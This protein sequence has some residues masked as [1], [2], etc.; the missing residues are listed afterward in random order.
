MYRA[1][2]I[3][4]IH[5]NLQTQEM[6]SI[7]ISSHPSLPPSTSQSKISPNK[8]MPVNLTPK[9]SRWGTPSAHQKALS[10]SQSRKPSLCLSQVV[11]L[12]HTLSRD[13]ITPPILKPCAQQPRPAATRLRA[14]PSSPCWRGNSRLARRRTRSSCPVKIESQ[15][16]SP[17]G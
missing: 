3:V 8:C 14:C 11:R 16:R 4:T 13:R 5:P 7:P 15:H 6:S 2:S 1:L 10:V 17:R 12:N 9:E